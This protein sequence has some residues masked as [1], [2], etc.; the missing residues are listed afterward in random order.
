MTL[1]IARALSALAAAALLALPLASCSSGGE[2]GD[3]GQGGGAAEDEAPPKARTVAIES[4]THEVRCGCKIEGIGKCG[5]YVAIEDDWVEIANREELGLDVMEWCRVPA[6]EHVM[7]TVAGTRTGDS[8]EL[9]E[10]EVQ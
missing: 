2:S 1:S 10:L 8:I 3:G 5:N 7:A 4:A 9:T 6:E